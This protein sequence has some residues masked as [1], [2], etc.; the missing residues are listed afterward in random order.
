MTSRNE[1]EI[2]RSLES[3]SDGGGRIQWMR[4][5]GVAEQPSSVRS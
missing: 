2:V 5:L 3:D 4:S 1:A